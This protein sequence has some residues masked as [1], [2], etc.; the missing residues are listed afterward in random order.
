MSRDVTIHAPPAIARAA[1]AQQLRE[2]ITPELAAEVLSG[3]VRELED[4]VEQLKTTAS[5]IASVA[6]CLTRVLCDISDMDPQGVR[7]PQSLIEHMK[8]AKI[9]ISE[10]DG[11]A[12]VRLRERTEYPVEVER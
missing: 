8:G 1:R 3:R 6:V 10:D 9:T 11:D 12:I 5:T 2:I 4:E 7:I